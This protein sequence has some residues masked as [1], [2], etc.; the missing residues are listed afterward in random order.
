[1]AIVDGRTHAE[2]AQY[3][4]VPIGTVKAWIRRELITLRDRLKSE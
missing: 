4:G 1:M 2:I 3:L